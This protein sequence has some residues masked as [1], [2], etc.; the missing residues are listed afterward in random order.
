MTIPIINP[1]AFAPPAGGGTASW[2]ATSSVVAS[3]SSTTL[4]IPRSQLGTIAV[5][6]LITIQA[7]SDNSQTPTCTGFT[8]VGILNWAG[9]NGG[10]GGR[11]TLLKKIAD[12]TDAAGTGNFSV[13]YP[14]GTNYNEA[15]AA[16]YVGSTVE[17]FTG[18][19]TTPTTGSAVTNNNSLEVAFTQFAGSSSNAAAPAGWTRILN[20]TGAYGYYGAVRAANAGTTAGQSFTSVGNTGFGYGTITYVVVP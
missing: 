12:S 18:Y 5:G 17:S 9:F 19:A 16:L 2:K 14:S 20:G 3:S 6:D 13:V 10:A 8:L 4:N 7:H 11:L 15:V 1:Y